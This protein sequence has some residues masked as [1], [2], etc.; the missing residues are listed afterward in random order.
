MATGS[1]NEIHA[2][3]RFLTARLQ[4]GGSPFTPEESIE[5]FRQYQKELQQCRDEIAPAI[6]QLNR[7]EGR[8]IDFESLK[9]DVT[10]K[11]RDEGITE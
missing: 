7:G 4:D 10:R 5:A 6:E 3:H 11:L 2:F 8:E 9:A 1:P